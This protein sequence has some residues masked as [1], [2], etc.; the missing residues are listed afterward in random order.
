MNGTQ[1]MSTCFNPT[2][3]K[4]GST[5]AYCLLSV[6]SLAG[7]TF[8]GMIVYR[9][10]TLR[11]PINI[12]I[13]NMAISD[14]WYTI[15]FF[16]K[17]LT[18][19][20]NA[21]HWLIS[22]P[23]GQAL[24]K[25]S[26]FAVDVSNLVSVQSLVLITVDRFV[27]VVF[28][29]R[30]PSISS[31]Q[32]WFFIIA[33]WVVAMAVYCPYLF[34]LKVVEDSEG[35][36]CRFQWN[37]AFG[38]SFS[39]EGY[40]LGTV[41]VVTYVPLVSIAILYFAIALTIKSQKSP[42]EQS[43]NLQ[44]G[45]SCKSSPRQV[46]DFKKVNL[47]DLNELF[48]WIPWNGAFL[49]DDVNSATVN[50]TDLILAAADDCI[51]KFVVKKK[52]NPPWITREGLRQVYDF[53]KVNLEDLNELFHWIPWN[54]AFLE[55]DVNSATVNVTDLILA[56][57]DDCIP[58]FVVKKKLNPPWITREG[59]RL[60]KKKRKLWGRLKSGASIQLRERFKQLRFETK[61]LI[62]SNYR[63]YLVK[64]SESLK[65]TIPSV[66]G[67][68]TP[69][70]P[71]LGDYL[72]RFFYE[73]VSARKPSEQAKL[74]N[75]HFHSVF[76]KSYDLEHGDSHP[77]EEVAPGSLISVATCPSEVRNILAKLNLNKAAGVD[78]IP[79]R[80][81]KCIAIELAKPVSWLFNSS[82]TRAIV[83]QLWKQANISPIHK[84]GDTGVEK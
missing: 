75:L 55:D 19:I 42:G 66:F 51:P 37:D 45:R 65:D 21:G 39:S 22:G 56:A 5:F 10:K 61:K 20:N 9:T 79:A 58:K 26:V 11:T 28:P 6:V 84:D 72:N 83:P 43:P 50:V 60:V 81:L 24:C 8:I 25:L 73:G 80:L 34:A 17:R 46:Y 16:T 63:E 44:S 68:F 13:V 82:F 47:E 2:A 14:L 64:L 59:L 31:K 4:I 54:G 74:L 3:E 36:A 12:L 67:R 76:S 71:N 35:L 53:K 23:L 30:S 77:K 57:A 27:A 52:L 18:E 33:I 48:H 40:F 29:L 49:E 78:S 70:K 41:I 32:C 38:E 62:R 15:I 69:S 7:N 1:S